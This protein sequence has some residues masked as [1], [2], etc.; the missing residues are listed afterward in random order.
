MRRRLL[1]WTTPALLLTLLGAATPAEP[2]HFSMVLAREGRTWRATCE[3][4]C[5]W[6]AVSASKPWYQRARVLIDNAGI[7]PSATSAE[8]T[9]TF[10]FVVA[11]D[12]ERGWKATS[13]RGTGWTSIGFTCGTDTGSCRA[14]LT[15]TSVEGIE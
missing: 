12:G 14:R 4:G 2:V 6:T 3:S 8:E 1:R 13:L 7:Y 11:P 10:A 15:E 9:A 5:A